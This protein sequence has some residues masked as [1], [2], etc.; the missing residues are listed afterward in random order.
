MSTRTDLPLPGCTPTPLAAYLKAL[1]VLRLVAEQGAD[2]GASGFWRDDVFVLRS[3]LDREHLLEF[4]LERYAP[5]PLIAPWNGGSGFYP[6]DN[7]EAVEAL[8]SAGAERFAAYRRAIALARE[9]IQAAKYEESPKNEDKAAFLARLRNQADE[10]LLRWMDAA[11]IL[12]EDSP[13][14]PPLLGTGGN[15]GRLDFTNNFMQRLLLLTEPASGKP[16][17]EAKTLLAA[18]LLA[19]PTHALSSQA[20]GQ[21]S[22]GDAGGPN[23]TAGFEGEARV[24][25]WDFVLML[26]GAVLLAASAVRR[27]ESSSSAVLSA[28]F[29]VRSRAGTVGSAA[30]GDDSDSRGEIWM[31]IWDRPFSFPELSALLSE[32]RAALGTRPAQDGL[33]F[34]RAVARLGVDRGLGAFQRYGFL[35]RSGK[36]FLATPLARIPVRRN[37][38]ADVIDDLDRN[39]WLAQVQRAARDDDTP[40]AFRAVAMRLDAALFSLTQRADRLSIE[41]VLR[42]LGRAEALASSSPKLRAKLAPVPRLSAA[43]A[44][45]AD[46]GSAEFRIAQALAGLSLRGEHDGKTLWLGLRPHLAPVALNG[47]AWD[48]T[49]HLPCWAVGPLERNLAALL[50]RR[51]LEALRLGAE[52]EVLASRTGATLDDL[53]RFLEGQ[54]DDRRIAE[55]AHGLAC[56]ERL[57]AEAPKGPREAALPPAFTF[58]KPFFTSEAMLRRLGW[59]AEDHRL[60]LPAEIPARLA[61]NDVPA[62]LR[63]AWQ[64][65]HALGKKL[66][67]RDPPE[68]PRCGDGPRLLAALVIP[69]AFGETHRLLSG[70]DLETENESDPITETTA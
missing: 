20:I 51:R 48:E 27:L 61:A 31:P 39:D 6:K 40:N 11:V 63:I 49:T 24:N 44:L 57:E 43:W 58:L 56:V 22:P 16:R 67:G 28:P 37:R 3:S 47:R 10:F 46:D 13:R 7:R 29:T 65:L 14:Y 54:T 1:A 38:D 68:P 41:R 36:A 12:A 69:L 60:R 4:F 52:G 42:L 62:A 26:E 19:E 53:G 70:L 9:F 55:L 64:R 35:M 25:P 45:K 30:G 5:T 18:S 59:L 34:A 15:D 21:F 2:P 66:P 23:A 32:G 33:D 8:A 50:H 17:N